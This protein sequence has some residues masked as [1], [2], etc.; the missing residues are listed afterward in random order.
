MCASSP[1]LAKFSGVWNFLILSSNAVEGRV[2]G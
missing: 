1:V 2:Y